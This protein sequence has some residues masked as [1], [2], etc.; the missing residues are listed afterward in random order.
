MRRLLLPLLL[1]ATAAGCADFDLQERIEDLR[2]LGVRAEPAEVQYA[3]AH[4]LFG[5]EQRPPVFPTTNLDIDV[6]V[7]AF[8]PRG[9]PI[10]ARV[11]LCPQGNGAC[12]TFD[13]EAFA[14]RQPESTHGDVEAAF[15]PFEHDVVLDLD[16]DASG[17]IPGLRFNLPL[18]AGAID[19]LI[20]DNRGQPIPQFFPLN[21]RI[22]MTIVNESIPPLEE[23]GDRAV[24]R[25]IAFKRV[26][27]GLNFGDPTLP[28]E[29]RGIFGQ[30]LGVEFCAEP[31]PEEDYVDGELAECFDPR[32]A[33]QNP[34]FI[35][36]QIVP[37]GEAFPEGLLE[38]EPLDLAPRGAR[39]SVAAG[40]TLSV[41]PV[42][43]AGVRERYQVMKFLVEES[44][45]EIEN[46]LEDL[47]V[48]WYST[49]GDLADPQR[50]LL[51][52]RHLGQT[53]TFPDPAVVE[54]G[55]E[56]TLVGVV[57]DQRGGTSF[58]TLTVVYR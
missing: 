52:E 35:G 32:P 25:E 18:R 39:L 43:A 34:D 44:T 40:A 17:R 49:R 29:V 41:N 30:I 10:D 3:A 54:P 1:L 50:D 46:R 6:E 47:V 22:G 20:P 5:P 31:I 2:I 38:D 19:A 55:D 14:D 27:V 56:D 4:V 53:W 28:P 24:F 15:E 13:N 21:P 8:D 33:N 26:P 48:T 7:L 11:Q 42:F 9:G 12:E 37:E 58:T 16:A 45:L 51:F 36:L 23:D 57:R